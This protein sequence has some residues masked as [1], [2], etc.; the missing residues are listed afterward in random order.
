MAK[1]APGFDLKTAV[2]KTLP[3]PDK[4]VTGPLQAGMVEATTLAITTQ[5]IIPTLESEV[6]ELE[7]TDD[8]LY[9]YADGLLGR[10]QQA[11][12]SWGN[13][14]GRIH[15][16]TIKPINDGMEAL[17]ELNR[18]IDRPLET[19]EKKV[20]GAMKGYKIDEQ[21][22]IAEA[23]RQKDEAANK[24]RLEA[25]AKQRQIETARTPQL[26]GKL[27]AAVVKLEQEAEAV[28]QTETP[29]P[30]QATHSGTRY[31]PKW[32]FITT[33]EEMESPDPVPASFRLFLQAIIDGKIPI[34][35]ILPNEKYINLVFKD[36][37]EKVA[38]WPGME[39]YD[40]PQI[41]GR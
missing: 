29:A 10:V 4:A 27:A 31:I 20:K 5:A 2:A 28:A 23:Q 15:A 26:K 1:K 21:K 17:Y 33:D 22:R 37:P 32:R 12:R 11:R 6:N 36:T 13:I 35:A 19:L 14:W 30:V 8:T 38:M 7:I 9:S 34:E 40:D 24:L 16:R 39:V 41:V 25:E 3:Q 18:D